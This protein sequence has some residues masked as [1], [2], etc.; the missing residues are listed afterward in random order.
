[1]G[2]TPSGR[3]ERGMEIT[4]YTFRKVGEGMEITPSGRWRGYGDYTFRK[5]GEGMGI[6][7]SGRV[8]RVW[9]LHLQEG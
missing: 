1:M 6:T 5:G 3:L 4:P 9:R 8:E 7:P 2:I